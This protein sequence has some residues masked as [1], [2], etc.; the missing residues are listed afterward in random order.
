MDRLASVQCD[1]VYEST[2]FMVF[3][4]KMVTFLFFY[5]RHQSYDFLS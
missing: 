5:M 1:A 4:V 2:L 3:T